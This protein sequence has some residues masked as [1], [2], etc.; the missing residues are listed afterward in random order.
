MLLVVFFKCLTPFLCPS[1]QNEV[2][3]IS[4]INVPLQTALLP[5]SQQFNM[6]T[7][8]LETFV[9]YHVPEVLGMEACVPL[10]SLFPGLTAAQW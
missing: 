3:L 4:W 10:L 9:I 6:L 8:F 5:W 7:V 1:F 2:V